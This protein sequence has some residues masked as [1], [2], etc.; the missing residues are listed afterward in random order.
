M[1]QV[2]R[3]TRYTAAVDGGMLITS[4]VRKRTVVDDDET[5]GE[6]WAVIIASL[7]GSITSAA[8]LASLVSSCF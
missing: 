3:C 2:S 1:K 6:G 5:P 7:A 8:V 4:F